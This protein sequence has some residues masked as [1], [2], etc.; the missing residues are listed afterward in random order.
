M[1]GSLQALLAAAEKKGIP[2]RQF[3]ADLY[4]SQMV[5]LG[6]MRVPVSKMKEIYSDERNISLYH[7]AFFSK[8]ERGYEFWNKVLKSADPQQSLAY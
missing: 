4:S 7:L 3:L 8:N 2:F 5:T 1:R 6:Y